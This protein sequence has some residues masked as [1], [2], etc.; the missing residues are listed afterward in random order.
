MRELLKQMQESRE[1]AY[2]TYRE[3]EITEEATGLAYAEGLIDG[4][5]QMITL[6][7]EKMK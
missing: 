4:I 1:Q 2:R 7:K 5:E 3:A 6:V